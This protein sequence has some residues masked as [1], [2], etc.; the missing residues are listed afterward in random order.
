MIIGISIGVCSMEFWLNLVMKFLIEIQ[1][2][3]ESFLFRR[4]YI[5]YFFDINETFNYVFVNLGFL[6]LLF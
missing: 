2:V 1:I 5:N 3:I 6:N 4:N